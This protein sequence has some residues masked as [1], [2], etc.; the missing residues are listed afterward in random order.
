MKISLLLNLILV[1][2]AFAASTPQSV[3]IA[4]GVKA[5]KIL[6]HFITH[7]VRL[8]ARFKEAAR[9]EKSAIA[10]AEKSGL[11]DAV[12][13]TSSRDNPRS[14]FEK[15][16]DLLENFPGMK[17]AVVSAC[18]TIA[19]CPIPDL[20]LD[21]ADAK[22]LPDSVRRL[23]RPWMALQQARGSEVE[24]TSIDGPG[25]AALS[26]KLKDI[27][28]QPLILNISPRL[29]GGFKVW[30]ERPL[31]LASLYSHERETVLRSIR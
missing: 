27:N 13:D 11:R 4:G 23:V 21:V 24:L 5:E 22:R 17:A 6:R 30:F 28:V 1:A 26:I 7:D 19:T 3:R 8:K 25:N 9:Y 18:R 14:D 31:V 2:P 29:P 12:S 20:A 16:K 10:E 15:R